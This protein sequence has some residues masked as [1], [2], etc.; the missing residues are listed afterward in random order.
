MLHKH[1]EHFDFDHKHENDPNR[2]S[3]CWT[4]SKHSK[5]MI[6]STSEMR[7]SRHPQSSVSCAK[8]DSPFI[9]VYFVRKKSKKGDKITGTCGR[10]RATLAEIVCILAEIDSCPKKLLKKVVLFI[11]KSPMFSRSPLFCFHLKRSPPGHKRSPPGHLRQVF[12]VDDRI[13]NRL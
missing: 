12:P 11:G 8:V 1:E 2:I 4:P 7:K 6:I 9:I 5:F 13:D 10:P 3:H